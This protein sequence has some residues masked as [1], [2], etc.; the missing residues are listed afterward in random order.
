MLT[1]IFVDLYTG[2]KDSANNVA[3]E[4]RARRQCNLRSDVPYITSGVRAELHQLLDKNIDDLN[5]ELK[6]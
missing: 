1:N 2:I 3:P 6:P 5:K 4:A